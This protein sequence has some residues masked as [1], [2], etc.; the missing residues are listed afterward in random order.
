VK[1]KAVLLGKTKN[2]VGVVTEPSKIG[3]GKNRPAIIFLN[4]GLIHR[5][6]PNRIYVQIA[7]RLA[8]SGFFALRLDLAGIG[9]SGNRTDNLSL[10]DGVISDVK[11]AMD[12]LSVKEGIHQFIL[13]GICSGADNSLRVAQRDARV[14]GAVPIE[15][16]YFATPAYHWYF[17]RRR[18]LKLKSWRRLVTMKSDFWR[19]LKRYKIREKNSPTVSGLSKQIGLEASRPFKA[20]IVSEIQHLLNRGVS[21]YL[22]YC[23][24]SPSYY[25]HYLQLRHKAASWEKF[26]VGLFPDTDHTFTLLANQQS[27]VNAIH[28]WVQEVAQDSSS[29][30]ACEQAV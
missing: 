10:K 13:V 4:A 3:S 11:D 26:S 23:V 28:D 29:H 9:D 20:E 30:D 1:E 6:G 15:A 14:I 24:D 25:N 7:R 5:V 16:Y 2:L 18:L 27:L 21:L 22:V 17:Y 19:I 8:A 12:F